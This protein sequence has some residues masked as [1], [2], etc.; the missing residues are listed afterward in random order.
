MQ[1]KTSCSDEPTN[2]NPLIQQKVKLDIWTDRIN[3][4]CS[5]GMKISVTGVFFK[6]AVMV[7]ELSYN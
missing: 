2:I 3:R 5:Y 7:V 4:L 6:G 1:K